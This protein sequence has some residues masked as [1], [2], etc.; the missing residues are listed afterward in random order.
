MNTVTMMGN[1]TRLSITDACHI[2]KLCL[3]LINPMKTD[4]QQVSDTRLGCHML[5]V[6][7]PSLERV[8]FEEIIMCIMY[9]ELTF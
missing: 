6:V 1:G 7:Y 9:L 8:N 3:S 5:S 4:F 2:P